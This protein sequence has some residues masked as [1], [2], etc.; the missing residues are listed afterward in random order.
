VNAPAYTITTYERRLRGVVQE[1][2]THN[3]YVHTHLDWYEVD[4]WL[5]NAGASVRVAYADRRVA[6]ILGISPPLDGAVWVRVAAVG[7]RYKASAVLNALWQDMLPELH[8]LGATQAAILLLRDW[9]AKFLPTI[10]F[11]YLEDIIT[12]RRSDAAPPDETLV[13][14]IEVRQARDED[15]AAI[16]HIDHAAFAPPWQMGADELTHAERSS[17]HSTVA[18]TDTGQ[19]IGYQMS[20]LYFDGAHL[21]RLAVHPQA[22]AHGVGH[23]L[24][25]SMLRHFNRRGVY[26]VSVNT[27]EDNTASQRLYTSFGFTRTGYDLPVWVMPL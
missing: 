13:P 17:A 25:G 16:V 7:D 15:T 6:G 19:I 24:V 1:L 21:A 23:L 26:S 9:P 14:G 27:Q 2:L 8:A 10:G 18:V 22:Q 20:T 11:H 4:D 3:F 12:L 5:A